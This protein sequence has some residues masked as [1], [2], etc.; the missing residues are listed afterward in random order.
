MS[1]LNRQFVGSAQVQ[2]QARGPEGVSERLVGEV[3]RQPGVQVALPV[4]VKQVNVVGRTGERAVDLIGVNPKEVRASGPLARRFSAQQ[5]VAQRAIA[6]P[7]PLAN[8]IGIGPLQIAKVQIGAKFIETLVGTTLSEADIGQ[9][10]HSPVAVA[11]ISYAQRLAG[12]P[13]Q[14]NLI[15]V[16]YEPGRAREARAAL[17]RLAAKWNVNLE[18]GHV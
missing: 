16:R 17:E 9:L 6:L 4:F 11:P 1:Q 2:L 13:G 8:E 18:P 3:R 5:L 15:F 10:V 14:I 12:T 7:A